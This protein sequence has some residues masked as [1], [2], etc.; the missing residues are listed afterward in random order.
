[1][2]FRRGPHNAKGGFLGG[3]HS[4]RPVARPCLCRGMSLVE[5]V[6]RKVRGVTGMCLVQAQAWMASR[7]GALCAPPG[8]ATRMPMNCICTP[9]RGER[10]VAYRGHVS[11]KPGPSL[12]ACG[13]RPSAG[14]AIQARTALRGK[15]GDGAEGGFLGGT[16]SVRPD[17]RAGRRG[18]PGAR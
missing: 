14:W 17:C 15:P 2:A 16:H 11:V 12:R 6:G 5:M 3:T 8:K 1:M 18:F 13:A 7:R 9:R 10:P 4:V